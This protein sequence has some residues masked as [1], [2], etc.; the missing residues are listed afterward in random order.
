LI[1]HVPV[2]QVLHALSHLVL[3]HTPPA[4][5]PLPQSLSRLQLLPLAHFAQE[6]PPQSTSDSV[7]LTTA[8]PQFGVADTGVQTPPLTQLNPSSHPVFRAAL[9]LLGQ[10]AA[11]PPHR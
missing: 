3:Q 10:P 8:S 5:E 6:F 1:K 4:H 2:A 9:Q 11:A 7:K